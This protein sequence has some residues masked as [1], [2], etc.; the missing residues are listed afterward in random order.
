MTPASRPVLAAHLR[1]APD[2]VVPGLVLH[3]GSDVLA[4]FQESMARTW[5][6]LRELRR[7]GVD[8]ESAAYLLPNA[9]AVRF[10]ESTDLLNLQHKLRARLCYNAQEEI[11]RASLD[12]AE[13]IAA[14]EPTVG[15]YLLPACSLRAQAGIRPP[16]PEGERYCGVAV[17]KLDRDRYARVI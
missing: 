10:S 12:E 5:D 3:A 6:A 15:R 17:W 13:Q 4:R 16:C 11:W 2:V 8:V 9:A 14:V 1:D 7:R